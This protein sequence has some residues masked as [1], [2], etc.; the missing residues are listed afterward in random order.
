MYAEEEE[1]MPN[2]EMK[3]GLQLPVRDQHHWA[4]RADDELLIKGPCSCPSYYMHDPLHKL[5]GVV[6]GG[7]PALDSWLAGRLGR[8]SGNSHASISFL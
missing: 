1:F 2:S 4:N 7:I 5:P 8:C 6:D 3:L